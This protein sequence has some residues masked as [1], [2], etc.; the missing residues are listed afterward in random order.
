MKKI[1]AI[2]SLCLIII[3]SFSFVILRLLANGSEDNFF[4]QKWRLSFGKSPL[5]RQILGLHFD[6]D[7][8]YDYLHGKDKKIL[9]EIDAMQGVKIPQDAVDLLVTKM[10]DA[11]GKRVIYSYSD[12]NIPFQA[13]SSGKEV[14]DLVKKYRNF[15]IAN[16]S[17]VYLLYLNQSKDQA[18]LLGSTYQE[19]G[20]VLYDKILRDFTRTNPKS[21]SNYVE[22]TALHEFGHQLGL[23]HNTQPDCLMAENA[24]ESHVARENPIDIIVDFCPYEKDLIMKMKY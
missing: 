21:F 6:G 24:E 12:Q 14:S 20:I 9:I 7:G 16:S 4:N 3:L 2:I 22:S 17:S 8:R 19:Y 5:L 10:Q 1:G 23:A 18:D 11:T 13:Q 15:Q